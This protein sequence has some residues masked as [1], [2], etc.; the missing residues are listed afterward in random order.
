MKKNSKKTVAK[1]EKSFML[2]E[3]VF[4]CKKQQLFVNLLLL[5]ILATQIFTFVKIIGLFDTI[6]FV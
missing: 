4:T 1:K 2:S 3:Q 5:T 6:T